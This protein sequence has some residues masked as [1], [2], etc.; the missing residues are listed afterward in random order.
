[1]AWFERYFELVADQFEA[2]DLVFL[3]P[4]A[5]VRFNLMG[6]LVMEL[7]CSGGTYSFLV[8]QP[9]PSSVFRSCLAT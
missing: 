9:C 6:H 8:C 5:L 1:M 7:F 3:V 4:H 2:V